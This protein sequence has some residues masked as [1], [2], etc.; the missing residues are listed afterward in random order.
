MADPHTSSQ[1]YQKE[2]IGI[3]LEEKGSSEKQSSDTWGLGGRAWWV[4]NSAIPVGG[5]EGAKHLQVWQDAQQH[6]EWGSTGM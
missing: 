1:G 4:W 6:M 3:I 5:G 2:E